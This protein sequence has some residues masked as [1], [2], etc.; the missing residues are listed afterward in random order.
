MSLLDEA[1]TRVLNT[2][3]PCAI[4]KLP[5]DLRAELEEALESDV[6]AE[7]ISRTLRDVYSVQIAGSVLRKHRAKACRSCHS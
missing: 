5:A 6:D 7:A 3:S 2:G 4:S 1:R